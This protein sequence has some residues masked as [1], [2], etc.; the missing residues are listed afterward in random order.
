LLSPIKQSEARHRRVS[1]FLVGVEV[2]NGIDD[3]SLTMLPFSPHRGEKVARSA[4]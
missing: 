2:A 1:A 3:G 4:G